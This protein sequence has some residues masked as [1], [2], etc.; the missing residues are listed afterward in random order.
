MERSP[1]AWVVVGAHGLV[2]AGGRRRRSLGE[3]EV[4][5]D[6]SR[7][8]FPAPRCLAARSSRQTPKALSQRQ[9]ARAAQNNAMDDER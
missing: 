8:N 7:Q 3:Y 9:L 1:M 4:A 5:A 6:S 2:S